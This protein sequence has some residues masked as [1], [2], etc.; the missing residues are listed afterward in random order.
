MEFTKKVYSTVMILLFL[1]MSVMTAQAQTNTV[2][3]TVNGSDGPVIKKRDLYRSS[4][5]LASGEI[6]AERRLKT[7]NYCKYKNN[8]SILTFV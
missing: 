6:V 8:I 7:L 1:C 2:K 3:G 4:S 5:S